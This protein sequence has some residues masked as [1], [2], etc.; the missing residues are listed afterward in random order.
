MRSFQ[1]KTI[2]TLTLFSLTAV[3]PLF[4]QDPPP[5]PPDPQQQQQPN[6]GW[7]R[8][9]PRQ[10]DPRYQQPQQQGDP[11]YAQQ[12]DPRYTQQQQ[13]D[14]RYG[15]QGPPQGNMQEP[16]PYVQ[17][18]ASMT[19]PAGAWITIRTNQVLS[20]DHNHAGDYFDATLVRPVIV[21]GFVVARQGQNLAGR[22]VDA[23][24]AGRVKGQS[25]LEIE[26]TELS[27]ADGQ[28]LPIKTSL[29]QYTGG[30]SYGRD[31]TAIATTTGAGALIGA[32]VNGGVGAGVG[33]A[34][35]LVASV[36]GVLVTRGR[37]TEVHPESILTFR[38]QAP[39][40]F[41]TERSAQAFHPV[42]Q[43]DYNVRA[44]TPR[45]VVRPGYGSAPIGYY[46]WGTPWPYGGYG[47]RY[48]YPYY[49]SSIYFGYGFGRGYGGYGY[50]G[51]G[52]R[53]R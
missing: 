34:G 51:G 18:P 3:A 48:G 36:V 15:Q 11:R 42:E 44:S 25:R 32:G 23:E 27:L 53:H 1:A 6:G 37:S 17:P 47:Y 5:P 26:I 35:G 12:G 46:G 38:L 33:A 39:V 40:T 14:P 13:G 19:I 41:S 8:F 21:N 24:K 4:S 28:Q 30:T 45:T 31:A 2:A 50:R 10:G 49:G 7:R 20:S 22:V 16:R 29:S 52:F 43:F 9:E